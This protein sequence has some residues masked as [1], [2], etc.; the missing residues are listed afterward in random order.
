MVSQDGKDLPQMLNMVLKGGVIDQ[1]VANK[2]QHKFP[3][4]WLQ[5]RVHS[6]LKSCLAFVNPNG[7]TLD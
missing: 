3:E 4:I 6:T 7:I 2:N 1:N 5:N